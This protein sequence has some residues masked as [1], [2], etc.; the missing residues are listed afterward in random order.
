MNGNY[1]FDAVFYIQWLDLVFVMNF[2]GR[3]MLNC[4]CL[5]YFVI[6]LLLLVFLWDANMLQHT[7]WKNSKSQSCVIHIER[8]SVDRL[9]HFGLI[10]CD[11]TERN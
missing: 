11:E 10:F 9:W 2:L 6:Q 1:T 7:L 5:T 8:I 4:F 3:H